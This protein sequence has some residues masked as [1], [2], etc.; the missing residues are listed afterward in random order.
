VTVEE[1]L[2]DTETTKMTDVQHTVPQA[3]ETG[4]AM[5][6]TMTARGVEALFPGLNIMMTE[7]TDDPL[8]VLPGVM[9]AGTDATTEIIGEET[10][11]TETDG[12]MGAI[13]ETVEIQEEGTIEKETEVMLGMEVQLPVK[14]KVEQD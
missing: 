1:A 10:A 2:E 3:S 8:T 11:T 4:Q 9:I 7:M 6:G 12:H 5:T 14:G 13:I